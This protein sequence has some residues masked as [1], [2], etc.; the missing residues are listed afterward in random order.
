MISP[1]SYEHLGAPFDDV[2]GTTVTMTDGKHRG[3]QVTVLH[4]T[5]YGSRGVCIKVRAEDGTEFETVA[6][7]TD[8]PGGEEG[9]S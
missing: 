6:S 2:D 4:Q 1:Q 9:A 8:M 7:A 5:G 3:Q